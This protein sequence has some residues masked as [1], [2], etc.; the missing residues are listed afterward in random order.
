MEWNEYFLNIVEQIKLKSKDE[1]TQVGALIVNDENTIVSTGY[2]SFPRGL[3][4][5]IKER[6]ERPIK[7]YYIEHAERNAI[8][9]AARLGV[10]TK[11]TNIYLTSGLP[12]T[13][14]ARAIINSGIKRIYCKKNCTTK[15]KEKWFESQQIALEMLNECGVDVI[16]YE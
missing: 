11:D 12:C 9:N 3:N 2:N 7:Y 4:D 14:C 16:Y 1:S 15:N 10:S 13:D 5:N 6:Q 8:F